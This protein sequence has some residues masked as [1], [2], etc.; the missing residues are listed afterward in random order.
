[1]GKALRVKERQQGHAH[2]EESGVPALLGK[3]RVWMW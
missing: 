2:V 1:V 3:V